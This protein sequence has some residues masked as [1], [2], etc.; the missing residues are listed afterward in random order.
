MSTSFRE[1][2]QEIMM[3]KQPL[4]SQTRNEQRG[5]PKHF[6][7]LVRAVPADRRLPVRLKKRKSHYVMSSH[8]PG[9][10]KT[11]TEADVM[12]HSGEPHKTNKA[13]LA[14]EGQ[15]SV[16]LSSAQLNKLK[17]PSGQPRQSFRFRFGKLYLSH[18]CRAIQFAIQESP[19]GHTT[20]MLNC[21]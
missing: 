18:T 5:K 9:V 2:K 11:T 12:C 20:L 7:G 16:V 8:R 15:V 21:Q 10:F 14:F 19:I 13:P 4:P 3:T 1:T 6:P 17:H